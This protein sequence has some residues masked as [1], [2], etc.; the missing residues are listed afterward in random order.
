[1][2]I[3]KAIQCNDIY[4]HVKTLQSVERL[5]VFNKHWVQ[6]ERPRGSIL[7]YNTARSIKAYRNLLESTKVSS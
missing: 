7:C 5:R 3:M 2:P 4:R 1:M 6:H